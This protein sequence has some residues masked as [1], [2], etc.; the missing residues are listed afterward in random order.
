[1]IGPTSSAECLGGLYSAYSEKSGSRQQDAYVERINDTVISYWPC[2]FCFNFA[3]CCCPCTLGLSCII[4]IYCI[5]E[6]DE[7]VRARISY[8]N[9]E[10]KRK[11]APARWQLRRKCCT[12]WI[13][14]QLNN[15][16]STAASADESKQ[17]KERLLP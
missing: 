16:A 15:G 10:L 6:A 9:A 3:Y 7:A 2:F 14:I 4:P 12:S 8:I 1:V 17:S 5:S 13:E 11:H